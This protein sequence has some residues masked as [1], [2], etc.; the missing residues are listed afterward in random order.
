MQKENQ[1]VA[2]S[3]M[4]EY[5]LTAKNINLENAVAVAVMSVR[6]AITQEDIQKSAGK[7]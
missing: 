2:A 3:G 4:Q 1:I 5:K 7:E 6:T